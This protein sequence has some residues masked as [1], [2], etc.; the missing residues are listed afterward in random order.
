MIIGL[1]VIIK[2]LNGA[3]KKEVDNS[4]PHSYTAGVPPYNTN[5]L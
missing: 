3:I 1:K 4:G 2:T 5:S